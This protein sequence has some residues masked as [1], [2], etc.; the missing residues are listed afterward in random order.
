G[1]SFREHSDTDGKNFQAKAQWLLSATEEIQ[2]FLQPY[3]AEPQMPGA[4]SPQDYEQER[5][6]S[7]RAYDDYEGKSTRWS[8]KY[9]HDVTVA[10]SA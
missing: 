10:D 5:H 9:I 1:E 7:K 8:D 3:D 2:A 4:L 6:Q